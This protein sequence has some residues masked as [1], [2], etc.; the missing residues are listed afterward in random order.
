MRAHV[1][2]GVRACGRAC[3]RACQVEDHMIW[4]HSLLYYALLYCTTLYYPIMWYY[5]RTDASVADGGL[6]EGG[7][8]ARSV[9]EQAWWY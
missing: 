4:G 1:N 5:P 8:Q 6:D 2:T 3:V 9:V 7:H